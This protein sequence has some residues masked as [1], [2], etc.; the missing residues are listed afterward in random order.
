MKLLTIFFLL[1]F[2]INRIIHINNVKY[3]SAT[4]LVSQVKTHVKV[5]LTLQRSMTPLHG[6]HLIDHLS[7]NQMTGFCVRWTFV[8]KGLKA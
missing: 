3:P 5:R 7:A 1:G 2:I 6:N 8:V 4:T